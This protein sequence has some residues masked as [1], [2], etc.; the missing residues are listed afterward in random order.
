MQMFLL[1]TKSFGKLNEKQRK[2][3]TVILNGIT[4]LEVLIHDILN[5][6]KVD[7]G[8]LKLKKINVNVEKLVNQ[9]VTEFR[10][11]S[12]ENKVEFNSY[13]QTS[14]TV[15]CDPERINQVFSAYLKKSLYFVFG[16]SITQS[17]SVK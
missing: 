10:P 15:E 7:I 12:D 2:D 13:M 9:I 11:L 5:V 17:P 16:S 8:K 6:H 4:N 1:S 3:I 14:G